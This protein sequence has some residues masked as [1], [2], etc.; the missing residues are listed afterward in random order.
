M[1]SYAWYDWT[2][3]KVLYK[4]KQGNKIAEGAFG[5]SIQEAEGN[6]YLDRENVDFEKLTKKEN[7]YHCPI[8][9]SDADYFFLVDGNDG[10]LVCWIYEKITNPAFKHIEGKVGFYARSTDNLDMEMS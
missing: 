4:D 3:K 2:M 7:A 1:A 8:K 5:E 6:Y 9:K 10:E